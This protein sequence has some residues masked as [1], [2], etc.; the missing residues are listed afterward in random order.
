MNNR[1]RFTKG[2]I[3]IA[4]NQF[5]ILASR[6][7]RNVI[8]ARIISPEDFGVGVIFAITISFLEMVSDAGF[9]RMLVQAKDGS[10]SKIQAN[11][12][13]M[14]VVRGILIS[15]FLFLLAPFISHL[16]KTASLTF[17]F[18]ILALVPVVKGFTHLDLVR[19]QREFRF[20]PWAK[21][22]TASS[23]ITTIVAWPLVLW[24]Q[25]YTVFLWIAWIQAGLDVLSSH[26]FS[27]RKYQLSFEWQLV[28]RFTTGT[29]A[30]I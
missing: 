2:G 25:D 27:T 8:I 1:Q 13:V 10:A 19:L 18:Y 30:R 4:G 7:I 12:Q 14:V 5:V 26:L 9:E 29:R 21:A 16:F 3:L 11:A 28:K 20:G 23:V 15:L 17:A 22:Q 6:F 24:R